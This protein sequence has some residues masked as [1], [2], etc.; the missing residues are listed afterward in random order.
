MLLTGSPSLRDVIAFPKTNLAT[1]PLDGAPG[2]ISEA[3]L[4]ELGLKIVAREGTEK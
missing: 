3:Q 4:A 1:S 2:G